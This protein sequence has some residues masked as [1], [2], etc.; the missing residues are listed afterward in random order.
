MPD[1][2]IEFCEKCDKPFL[3]LPTRHYCDKCLK[4]IL[5]DCAKKRGLNKL[6]TAANSAKAKLRKEGKLHE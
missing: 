6:G 2:C 4:K 5:S 1:K 3:A